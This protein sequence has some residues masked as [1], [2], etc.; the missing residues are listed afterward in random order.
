[1]ADAPRR[2]R[3]VVVGGS[4]TDIED[5]VLARA[6]AAGDR[7]ALET[8]LDRHVDRVHAVCRRVIAHPEDALDATQE[9]LLAI[10]RGI[11]RY[12]GRAAFTTWI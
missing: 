2:G 12:D 11:G 9:A 6:A 3:G 7:R 1:M 4:A 8:L 10:A 5:K